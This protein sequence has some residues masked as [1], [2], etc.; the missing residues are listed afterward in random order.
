[1]SHNKGNNVQSFLGLYG[2]V[3][4]LAIIVVAL[5]LAAIASSIVN[6]T[7]DPNLMMLL[8]SFVALLVAASHTAGI[9]TAATVEKI[10]K[11]TNGHSDGGT[12]P[13]ASSS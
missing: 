13:N 4:I 9:S 8:I 7:V 3:L 12:P 2:V 10:D 6:K 1:M 5:A 11:Q